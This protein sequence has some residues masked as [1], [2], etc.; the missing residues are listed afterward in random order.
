MT[1]RPKA[2]ISWSSGKDSAFSLHEVRRA[3]EIDVVGALTTVTENFGRVS[4]HGVREEILRAQLDAAG[5][6]AT[7]VPIPYSCP[8]EVYEARMGEAIAQAKAQGI[9]H[10]IFGDLFLEDIR[11]YREETLRGTG[12]TPVFPLWLRPTPQLARDMI[13]NG[14]ETYIATVDLKK[15]PAAFAGRCFDQRLLDELPASVDP[16]GENGEFHTCV[17]GGPMFSKS[18]PVVPGE[19]VQ[20]DGYAYCDLLLT[21]PAAGRARAD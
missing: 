1:V 14:L 5:L 12:V 20:R 10:M 15:M 19:R 7:V 6:P 17:V 11:K 18:L 13:A 4:I 9:T 8:N 16:C 21:A 3:G 2:M